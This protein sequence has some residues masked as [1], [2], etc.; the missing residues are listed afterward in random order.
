[1]YGCFLP[2]SPLALHQAIN[3]A[4]V[5]TLHGTFLISAIALVVTALL[6]A[7]L[8]QQK[9]RQIGTSVET[10]GL[11]EATEALAMQDV[12]QEEVTG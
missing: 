9:Q 4:F 6:V 7:F 11:R 2:I 3:Q 12:V 10:A 5:D 8:L 1:M